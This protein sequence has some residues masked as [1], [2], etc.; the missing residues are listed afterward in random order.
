LP[1][2][3]TRE[4]CPLPLVELA[5]PLLDPGCGKRGVRLL[6]ELIQ[7]QALGPHA[8]DAEQPVLACHDGR[9][10]AEDP[11][12]LLDEPERSGPRRDAAVGAV[13]SGSRTRRA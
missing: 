13:D 8:F 3:Q 1:R 6:E 5:A 2:G 7:E 9:E 11:Q 12:R 10:Q 4:D